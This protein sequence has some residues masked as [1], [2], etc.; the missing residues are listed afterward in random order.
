MLDEVARQAPA[1]LQANAAMIRR[2][3]GESSSPRRTGEDAQG[4]STR[5]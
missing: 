3:D 4:M 2:L 5:A 1:L